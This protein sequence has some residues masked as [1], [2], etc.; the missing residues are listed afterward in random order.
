MTW[1]RKATCALLVFALLLGSSLA[2]LPVSQVQAAAGD[3]ILANFITR[4]GDKLYDGTDELR[5]VTTNIPELAYNENPYWGIPDPWEQEDAIRTIT[6]MGGLVARTYTISVKKASDHPGIKRHVIAPGQFDEDVFAALDKTLQLANQYGVRLIIPLVC[7]WEWW[8]GIR[9]YADFRGKNEAD[10]WSDPQVIADFKQTI[11]Y[12]LNRTNIYTGVKYKD[13]KAILAW[14][15]GN[16]LLA[17]DA[18]TQEIA[19]YIK[20]IDSNHLVMDGK[21]ASRFGFSEEILDDPN[22][23]I[24]SNHYY[25]MDGADYKARNEA[26]R[27]ATKNKKPLIVGE[28]G[29]TSTANMTAMLNEVIE[30]GTSGAMLWSIRQHSKDGGFLIHG[31]GDGYFAYHWPGFPYGDSYDETNVL[32]LLQQKAY[33]I[34]G[35]PVPPMEVPVAPILLPIDAVSHINWRGSAGANS[36]VVERADQIDGPWSVVGQN[37]YDSVPLG[38]ALFHDTSAATGSPYYYRVKAVNS[39]GESAYSNVAGPVVA[40]HM[41][42]DEMLSMSNLY[43]YT[44]KLKTKKD[45]PDDYAGDFSKLVRKTATATNEHIVY[46]TPKDMHSFK[47]EAFL[48]QDSEAH[49]K[50][51]I[52]DDYEQFTEIV[53]TAVN[54]GEKNKKIV[55]EETALPQGSRFLKIEFPQNTGDFPQIGKVEIEYD[56]DGGLLNLEIPAPASGVLTDDLEDFGQIVR[57]SPN[58]Y[59]TVNVPEYLGGDNSLLTRRTN[60]PEYIVY[61][62]NGNINSFAAETYIWPGETAP[63]TDF[64]FYVSTDDINYTKLTPVKKNKGGNWIRVDYE[65][66]AI[67]DN[68]TYLKVE[69]PLTTDNSAWNPQLSNMRI[70]FGSTRIPLPA[71]SSPDIVDSFDDYG[72]DNALLRSAYQINPNGDPVTLT[73]DRT[74]L[75]GG[76]HG[77]KFDYTVGSNGYSGV[78]KSVG[79]VDWSIY[80]TLQFWLKPDGSS[81]SLSIDIETADG[82]FWQKSIPLTGTDAGIVTVPLSSF[83]RPSW[84]TGASGP[85]DLSSVQSFHL[86]VGGL[87]LGSGTIYLDSIRVV[88]SPIWI[89]DLNDFTRIFDKSAHIGIDTGNSETVGDDSRF[90]RTAESQDE[91]VVYELKGKKHAQISAGYWDGESISHFS[92]FTSSDNQTWMEV[93]PSKTHSSTPQ[94]QWHHVSY[95]LYQLPNDA[96]YLKIKWGNMDGAFWSPQ[97]KRVVLDNHVSLIDDFEG[98][99]GNGSKLGSAYSRNMAGD[100]VT[101]A[102]DSV[103]KYEGQYGMKYEY[104]SG[105]AS[106]AGMIKQLGG[107]SWVGFNALQLWLK[108]DGSNNRLALQFKETNGE[109]WETTLDLTGSEPGLTVIPFANFAH[110]IWFTGGNGKIDLN[111]IAE[112]SIYVSTNGTKAGSLYFDAIEVVHSEEPSMFTHLRI[113]PN[114]PDGQNGWYTQPVTVSLEAV[115]VLNG[116]KETEFRIND[117][118]WETYA[119]SIPAFEDGIYTL[120]YRSTDLA[121]LTEPMKTV[122]FKVSTAPPGEVTNARAAAGSGQVEL[123]WTDPV[124]SDFRQV[125]ITGA[126]QPAVIDKGV[127]A[128]VLTGLSPGMNYSIRITTI[129]EAGNESAGV[130]LSVSPASPTTTNT[131]SG[132][133]VPTTKP[134]M[135]SEVKI[136]SATNTATSTIDLEMWNR[137]LLEAASSADG[138]RK[139]SIPIEHVDQAHKYILKLPSAAVSSLEGSIQIEI[140]TSFGTIAVPGHLLR[141]SG[142]PDEELEIHIS[143]DD[144]DGQHPTIEWSIRTGTRTIAWDQ[145]QMPVVISIPYSPTAE[146][147]KKPEHLVVR[148]VD[149]TGKF[150]PVPNGK[151]DPRTGKVIFSATQSGGFAILFVERTFEDIDS[152]AWAKNQIE[153]L[154]A[155]GIINGVS[156]RKFRPEGAISRADF[157]VLLVR[158]LELQG[159]LGEQFADVAEDAYYGKALRIARALGIV[160]GSG[161]NRFMPQESVTREDMMVMTYR[162]LIAANKPLPPIAPD[163]ES[164]LSD[165]SD[166]SAVSGYARESIVA[167]VEMGLIQGYG[168]E[169]HPQEKSTRAQSAVLMYK[170]YQL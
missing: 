108:P 33:E 107:V 69:F 95:D 51:Y 45:F 146:E 85:M 147:L 119:G 81:R 53:P 140:E 43:T 165:F 14:E 11:E 111:S 15:T 35:L 13:D 89:D 5:F 127:Q 164:R 50:F 79:N 74:I 16:E 36:Y 1:L 135:I 116:V 38:K 143:K 28:F 54:L 166:G 55:Y 40:K 99:G 47:M 148:H 84:Q 144:V 133:T 88:N 60:T 155:K 129:N 102:L 156:E 106:Y 4:S 2:L 34:R 97:L 59:F 153:V 136:D 123:T 27:E 125:R 128:V 66:Y 115:D 154:A 73:L 68:M 94:G 21:F 137:A 70:G 75:D 157:L 163:S 8:G 10:F 98:Y 158:T 9:Q 46:A 57:Y 162:A 63:A 112:F 44:P 62:T 48:E 120:D 169:L 110:P 29:L 138:N 3:S 76:S 90:W 20:S 64:S 161:N 134:K 49:F 159:A 168:D 19:A 149:D 32:Q 150:Q 82:D 141:V 142:L 17:P 96:K 87:P 131:S 86:T 52:S 39:A 92:F 58:L 67:P 26:D 37:V 100:E 121:G 78:G 124:D 61:R 139:I 25:L 77:L 24:V 72:S 117:G 71:E 130:T 126:G 103:N 145:P 93:M 18:W 30:N 152:T 65:T 42:R 170:L 56:H 7:Q 114:Q 122:R 118:T 151:Y 91:W 6:Q 23:D 31:E 41:I 109:Y 80:D 22:I 101:L 132:S 83:Q 104:S 167:L 105:S 113:T 160:T 12:L